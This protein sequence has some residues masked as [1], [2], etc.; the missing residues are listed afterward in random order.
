MHNLV[1]KRPQQQLQK[2]PKVLQP[3]TRKIGVE[4][5]YIVQAILLSVVMEHARIA[6]YP[7]VFHHS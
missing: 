6:S 2:E 3:A 4:Q 5:G 7:G 1:A